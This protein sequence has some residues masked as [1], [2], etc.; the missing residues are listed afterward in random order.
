MNTPKLNAAIAKAKLEF[1]KIL[2]NRAVT[3]IAKSGREIKFNYAELEDIL[4]AVTP[5]L[6]SNGLCLVSQLQYLPSGKFVLYSTLRHESGEFIE[7]YFPLSESVADPKDLGTQIGYGRRYNA[8]CLLEISTVEPSDT[9]QV[10]EQTRKFAHKLRAEINQ[11][12]N[13]VSVPKPVTS[14][15]TP[16]VDRNLVNLEIESTLKRKNIPLEDA[17]NLL[18]EKFNARSRSELSDDQLVELL[19]VLRTKPSQKEVHN[20]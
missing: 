6:S 1:P 2:A 13:P 12:P 18:A 15:S 7:S 4:D 20:A 8:L 19:E 17:K 14:F 10:K 16:E 5:V 3:I 11:M 9:E